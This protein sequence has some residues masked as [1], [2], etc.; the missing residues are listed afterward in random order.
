[1]IV[2]LSHTATVALLQETVLVNHMAIVA[3]LPEI[4]LA[5][6]TLTHHDLQEPL[7]HRSKDLVA[8]ILARLALKSCGWSLAADRIPRPFLQGSADRNQVVVFGS[9]QLGS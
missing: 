6:H 5:N 2:L 3:L 4:V 8:Q 9:Y 1:M 7:N